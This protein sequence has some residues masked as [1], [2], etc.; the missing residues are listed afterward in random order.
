MPPPITPDTQVPTP[1]QGPSPVPCTCVHPIVR[2]QL[3]LEAELLATAIALIGFLAR[4]DAFVT[5]E[6]AL[7]PEAAAT[8]LTL[9]RVVA[10][11]DKGL[12]QG[13]ASPTPTPS[14]RQQGVENAYLHHRSPKTTSG[15]AAPSGLWCEPRSM[16][17]CAHISICHCGPGLAHGSRARLRKREPDWLQDEQPAPAREEQ[18]CTLWHIAPQLPVL[19]SFPFLQ[20]RGKSYSCLTDSPTLKN[21]LPTWETRRY[22]PQTPSALSLLHSFSS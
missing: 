10:C 22:R 4:V 16:C 11:G 12:N 14:G 9:I 17:V 18:T 3:V 7:I 21:A 5:L 20:V 15:P 2:L 6:G 19:P 1:A 8:E 13:L